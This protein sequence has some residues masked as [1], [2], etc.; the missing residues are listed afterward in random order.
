MKIYVDYNKQSIISIENDKILYYGENYEIIIIDFNSLIDTANSYPSLS[1]TLSDGRNIYPRL[2]DADGLAQKD[3]HTIYTFTLTNSNGWNLI[4]GKTNFYIWL[5]NVKDQTNICCGSFNCN[6]VATSG[7]YQVEVPHL[8]PKLQEEINVIL[9]GYTREQTSVKADTTANITSLNSNDGIYISTTDS[10]WY[11]WNGQK[12]VSSNVKLIDVLLG[13]LTQPQ[14]NALNSGITSD[15]IN[16]L[17]TSINGKVDSTS[18]AYDIKSTISNS[19]TFGIELINKDTE[20]DYAARAKVKYDEIHT[21]VSD[22]DVNTAITQDSQQIYIAIANG[23]ETTNITFDSFDIYFNSVSIVTELQIAQTDIINAESAI[24]TNKLNIAK[25][26]TN[27]SQSIKDSK[28]REETIK[29]DYNK[30]IKAIASKISNDA[31]ENN[32]LID[33]AYVDEANGTINAKIVNNAKR[34]TEDEINI[35]SLKEKIA[36]TTTIA[37]EAKAIAEGRAK[38]TVYATKSD[39]EAALINAGKLDFKVGDNLLIVEENVPD[40]WITK[41]NDDRVGMY[42]FFNVAILETQKTDLSDYYNKDETNDLMKKMS[43]NLKATFDESAG[44]LM[45]FYANSLDRT[46]FN[47]NSNGTLDIWTDK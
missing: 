35:D 20:S 4:S 23:E 6:I 32:K 26:Q 27:L 24:E 40:Y 38:A 28:A 19:A 10:C 31:T 1:A 45:L 7:Y 44:T 11:Y 8:N 14:E 18:T 21:S 37:N 47:L 13:G 15:K 39:M 30:Q 43:Y 17:E 36:S 46:Y 41:V 25:N 22:G 2:H 33:K 29:N 42:G 34:L 9:K 3:G 16:S 12:Y 5:S